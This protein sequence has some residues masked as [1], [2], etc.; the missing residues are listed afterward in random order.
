MSDYYYL[1]EPAVIS[2]TLSITPEPPADSATVNVHQGSQ[3]GPVKETQQLDQNGNGSLTLDLNN[4]TVDDSPLFLEFVAQKGDQST[5]AWQAVSLAE[6]VPATVN[7]P[8]SANGGDQIQLQVGSWQANYYDNPGGQ[9]SGNTPEQDLSRIPDADKQQVTWRVNGTDLDTKG[10]QVTYTVDAGAAGQTLQVE[11][12]IGTPSGVAV[13]TIQ[14]AQATSNEWV[15]LLH[16]DGQTPN[17]QDQ[18][19]L[20]SDDGSINQTKVVATDNVDPDPNDGIVEF[21]FTG[22][23]PSKS[24]SLQVVEPGIDPYYLFQGLAYAGLATWGMQPTS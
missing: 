16:L 2:Y 14:V 21:H 10:D 9:P 20:T 18:F 5:T 17:P 23:D 7:V 22:L 3:G 13:G 12:Y 8:A 19:I 11:A 6:G 24:Y 15:L 4:Y 1:H